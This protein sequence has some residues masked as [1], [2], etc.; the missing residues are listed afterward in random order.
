MVIVIGNGESRS[1]VNIKKVTDKYVTVACNAFHRDYIPNSLVCCD[2]D[3]AIEALNNPKLSQSRILVRNDFYENN[4]DR[5]PSYNLEP[6]PQLPFPILE[7]QDESEHWG[8]GTYAL[9]HACLLD[10]DKIYLLGFD[11]YGRN[12]LVNN[13]YKGTVNYSPADS[14][15]VD[16]SYWIYQISKIFEHFP[17]KDFYVIN[18]AN[19]SLPNQWQRDN[20]SFLDTDY[21]NKHVAS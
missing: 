15:P 9:L 5:F 6:V 3:T 19:W 18:D 17:D 12:N 7:R 13:C 11:L 14:Q 1:N 16:P 20:V 21:F 8:S 4:R 10:A 2:R